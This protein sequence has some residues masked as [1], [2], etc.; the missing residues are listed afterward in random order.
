[1]VPEVLLRVIKMVKEETHPYWEGRK[2][3]L[4]TGDS[5]KA[6]ALVQV[7]EETGLDTLKIVSEKASLLD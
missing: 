4:S 2:Q 6:T 1:M 5:S 3:S 7:R